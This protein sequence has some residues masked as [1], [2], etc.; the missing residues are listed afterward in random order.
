MSQLLTH[1]GS[2][3]CSV[4]Q[5]LTIPEPEKTITYQ[6][7]NHYD[8]AVNT[9]TVASDLIRGFQFVG[10]QYALSNDGQKMFG[11]LN[12]QSP[13]QDSLKLSIGIRNS[14]D[15][16]MA[17]G[18]CIG[19][20]VIVCD[21]LMFQGEVTV[22]RKHT[23]ENMHQELQDDIVTAIYKSQHQFTKLSEDAQKMKQTPMIRREKYQY[24]GILTGEKVLSPTQSTKAFRELQEPSHEEFHA[25]SLWSGYNAATEALKSSPPQDI[26]KRHSRLHQIT[27]KL[28]LN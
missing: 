21:N 13:E 1:C 17:A 23:G 18:L 4:E 16:S 14:Y 25:D 19:A 5:L 3:R 10:D 8:F 6:P 9:L 26:I 12:Y 11:I 15:K 28:Y 20:S 7:L 22:L 2:R 27:R 24:L